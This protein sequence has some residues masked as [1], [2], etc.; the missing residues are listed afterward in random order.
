MGRSLTSLFAVAVL[1]GIAPGA[2]ANFFSF[3]PDDAGTPRAFTS[4]TASGTSTLRFNVGD[5]SLGFNGGVTFRPG[6]GLFYA[7]ANDFTGASSLVS[8]AGNGGGTST[9]VAALG[10]GFLGGLAYSQADDAFYAIASDMFGNSR[11]MR[12]SA[13]GTVTDVAAIGVGFFGGLTLHPLDG[14]LYAI[15]GDDLGVQRNLSSITTSGSVT[16]LFALGDGLLA[17]DGGLAVDASGVFFVVSN[18]SFGAS[19]LN[20]FALGDGGV[21]LAP[22][23]GPFGQGFSNRGLVVT[24]TEVPAPAPLSLTAIAMIALYV[25]RRLS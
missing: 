22:V 3:G 25:V 4:L 20:T 9:S 1:L 15:S 16:S 21:S 2:R 5:G 10:N 11:L 6:D 19:T 12:I 13:S 17:F 7:V 8:F 24:P 14:L 23:D 18:D